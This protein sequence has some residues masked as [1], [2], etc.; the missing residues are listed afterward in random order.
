MKKIHVLKLAGAALVVVSSVNAWSQTSDT[1][2]TGQTAAPA[3]SSA[4]PSKSAMRKANRALSKKVLQA[5]QKG[6]IDVI[7]MNVIAKNGAITLAGH[8]ADATEIDKAASIAKGVDGVTSVKNVL[9][10]QE[11]GQ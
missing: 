2:A 10:I 11:G 1:A 6:G 8:A 5:L 3:A 9:T 7:G 4:P